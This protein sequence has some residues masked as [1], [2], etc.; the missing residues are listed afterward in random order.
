MFTLEAQEGRLFAPLAYTKTWA[1]AAAAGLSITLV[2]A[3]MVYL[4]RGRIR[5]ERDNPINR[6]LIDGYQPLITAAFK[7]P[8][9][10]LVIVLLLLASSL[11]PLGRLGSEFMPELDEG[12]LL[13][14]P[15]TLPGISIGKA[16][17]LLQQTD[18][19]IRTVPEVERVFGKAGRAETATDPAPLTMIET[20]IKLKP[21]EQWRPGMTLEKLKAELDARVQV[22]GLNNAWLMPIKT[23]IDMQSTGINTPVG[24]KIA[25]PDLA[26]IEGIGE[27]IER[28]LHG[29]EGTQSVYSERTA[30]ARYIDIE[31]NRHALTRYSTPGTR[32]GSQC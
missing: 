9:V 3:L 26:V 29:V 31:I 1:M 23:R 24:I 8:G 20:T 30:S 12:D 10:T 18:R 6:W 17:E 4:I 7:R 25:G 21:R 16:R 27:D 15:T 22:P 13:Y 2:P 28:V 14:M 5:Q 11:W 32:G 19:L